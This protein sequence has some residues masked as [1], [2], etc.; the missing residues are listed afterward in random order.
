MHS[1]IMIWLEAYG[2]QV[3]EHCGLNENILL[4]FIESG[5]I[6]RFVLVRVC[7]ILLEKICH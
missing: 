5:T 1:H 2:K 6:R 7:M 3:L 4:S